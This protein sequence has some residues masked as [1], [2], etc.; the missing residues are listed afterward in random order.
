MDEI[1]DQIRGTFNAGFPYAAIAL[2]V[3][4]PDI[5]ANLLAPPNANP[6]H[7]K[8]RFIR[9]FDDHLA[10]RFPMLD[11]ED[12][13]S[14]R[15]GLTHAGKFGNGKGS[16]DRFY[17]YVE[18]AGIQLASNSATRDG[19]ESHNCSVQFLIDT[20]IEAAQKWFE[21][22]QLDPIVAANA[23]RLVRHHPR[24]IPGFI[25]GLPVIG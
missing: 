23:T 19:E 8:K 16:Y 3:T 12:F 9:W 7:Q 1:F 24:G 13:W 18:P 14:L 2:A 25:S 4:V 21:A 11:G 6:S 20:V 5:C 17:F 22:S 15:C 10:A